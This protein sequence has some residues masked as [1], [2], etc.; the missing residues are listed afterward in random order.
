LPFEPFGFF[1]GIT[2]RSL[3]GEDFRECSAYMI[4][5]L[6]LAAFRPFVQKLMEAADWKPIVAAV[7]SLWETSAA[8]Y[9]K[10]K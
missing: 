10:T 5:A 9:A 6:G 2:H 3:A 4:S 7:P 8:E 1:H